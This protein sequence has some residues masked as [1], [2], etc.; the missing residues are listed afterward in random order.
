MNS[1]SNF[2]SLCNCLKSP[3]EIKLGL[4]RMRPVLK[5]LGNPH[6][7]FKSIICAGTNGKG[8]TSV[9]IQSILNSHGLKTGLYT[10]PHLHRVN[11]R[12]RINYTEITDEQLSFLAVKIDKAAE[13]AEVFISFF[14]LLTMIAFCYFEQNNIDVAVLEVGMGGRL[15]A[16]NVVNAEYSVITNIGL[17]HTKY[18]GTTFSEIAYEKGEVARA[19][20]NCI[21]QKQNKEVMDYYLKLRKNAIGK[22]IIE[23]NDYSVFSNETV[24]RINVVFNNFIINNIDCSLKGDF[25]KSNIGSAVVCSYC[26]LMDLNKSPDKLL[27]KK[28]LN[29]VK[30]PGRMERLKIKSGYFKL[31][32]SNESSYI[33]IVKDILV[34]F[35]SAHNAS[36]FK[37]IVLELKKFSNTSITAILGFYKDKDAVNIVK[38]LNQE[39]NNMILT[40]FNSKRAMTYTELMDFNKKNPDLILN[41][42]KDPVQALKKAAQL[43]ELDKNN[44]SVLLICGSIELTGIMRA[45]LMKLI[46][47]I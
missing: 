43:I 13:K 44:Q 30:W 21:I 32:T 17:D 29:Q 6:N 47:K 40:Q 18:L 31:N 8:S 16:T 1:I 10:S 46:N 19:N 22:T 12:I 34:I 27:I 45:I 42:C 7:K 41:I 38:N 20:K 4:E 23:G 39:C 37:S 5:I 9:M 2:D 28:S 35:D 33:N 26:F 15:D 3:W 11:E 14:E 24:G 25:Q 36:A